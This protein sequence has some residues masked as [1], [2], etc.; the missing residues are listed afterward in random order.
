MSRELIEAVQ[1]SDLGKIK[2]LIKRRVNINFKIANRWTSLYFAVKQE[3]IE[4]AK[5]LLE[6][7]AIIDNIVL[8]LAQEIGNQDLINLL[9]GAKE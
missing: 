8:A 3:N 2:E 5:L 1:V 7:N 9:K 4:I 6:A